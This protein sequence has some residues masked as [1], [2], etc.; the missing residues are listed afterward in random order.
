MVPPIRIPRKPKLPIHVRNLLLQ[1]RLLPQRQDL[2]SRRVLNAVEVRE[3]GFG[4]EPAY[5]AHIQSAL[6]QQ[7]DQEIS[8]SQAKLTILLMNN[9]LPPLPHR[10]PMVLNPL[11]SPLNSLTPPIRVR[12]ESPE[13]D[14]L[15]PQ[16]GVE[17]APVRPV[18]SPI[19]ALDIE[20]ALAAGRDEVVR[21]EGFD[22]RAH[23]V[24]P[25]RD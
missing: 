12:V 3:A 23:L 16:L 25:R 24:V 9:R 19:L 11:H 4:G 15:Q 1:T 8:T 14:I 17:I 18:V 7:Q 20:T 5:C 2:D 10:S 6:P 22:V 21:V 13:I